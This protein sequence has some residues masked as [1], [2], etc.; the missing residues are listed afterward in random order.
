MLKQIVA[1]MAWIVASY[2]VSNIQIF[3]VSKENFTRYFFQNLL[4]CFPLALGFIFPN[5]INLNAAFLGTTLL[6]VLVFTE[7][8]FK[9]LNVTEKIRL[10]I[11]LF[12]NAVSL[13]GGYYLGKYVTKN[14]YTYITVVTI[15]FIVSIS[16]GLYLIKRYEHKKTKELHSKYLNKDHEYKENEDKNNDNL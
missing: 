2:A 11:F 6:L 16:I 5:Y 7:K 14:F 9:K 1:F 8:L 12:F 15:I 3:F 10:N 13:N 4:I